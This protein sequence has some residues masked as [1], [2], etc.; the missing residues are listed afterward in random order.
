MTI[1]I[2][3][4]ERQLQRELAEIRSSSKH[5]ADA[6]AVVR[7][8]GEVPVSS[9]RSM[10]TATSPTC[11]SLLV[12]CVG[13]A[14]SSPQRCSTATVKRGR[15]RKPSPNVCSVKLTRVSTTS[16]NVYI[17]N[18]LPKIGVGPRRKRRSKPPMMLTL[19][20]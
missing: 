17:A 15:M 20:A 3:E 13:L 9:S 7:G 14:T 11:G 10:R 4:W 1:D 6:I 19:S 18:K 2:Q 5:L 8:R 16:F 12:P